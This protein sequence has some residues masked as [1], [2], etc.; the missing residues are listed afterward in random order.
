[1]DNS[2]FNYDFK[3]PPAQEMNYDYQEP[4]DTIVA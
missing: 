1:M 2:E 3:E 4:E